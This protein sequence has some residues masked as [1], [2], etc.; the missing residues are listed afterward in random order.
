[1][2]DVV[3]KVR[4]PQINFEETFPD[5]SPH[6]EFAHL[7]NSTSITPCTLEPFMIKVFNKAKERLDP[8]KDAE[9]VREVDWFNAQ[10][11]QHYRAHARFNKCFQTARYPEMV[12][13]EKEMMDDLNDYFENNSLEFCL[14][15]AEGFESTGSIWYRVWFEEL[16]EFRKASKPEALAL[17]DWHYAEEY[18][19]REVAFKL[20]MA[21]AARG[22]LWRKIYYGWW[23]RIRM[24]AFTMKHI[25]YYTGRARKHLLEIDRAEMTPE[26]SEASVARE[27]AMMQHIG[28]F[29][30]KG[31][32]SIMS[33]FYNPANKPPPRGY[34]AVLSQ[35]EPGSQFGHKS[36]AV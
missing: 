10:E 5:W 29:M 12:G 22:S 11:A 32:L 4:Y 6:L 18:E 23:Y 20:Y 15:Y 17:F 13:I 1:M 27:R 14:G 36:K 3:L 28:S 26:E 9:L 34:E 33:P 7:N 25:H 2:E 35:F 16:D 8:V 19:H 31:A 24:A 30:K 21:V